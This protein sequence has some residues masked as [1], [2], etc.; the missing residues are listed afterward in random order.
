V[1]VCLSVCLSG[2]AAAVDTL[3]GYCGGENIPQP[4]YILALM[5]EGQYGCLYHT[6]GTCVDIV[7]GDDAMLF[8]KIIV[9]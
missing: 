1:S 7:F 2:D 8:L 9:V 6:K 3:H 4:A 5:L